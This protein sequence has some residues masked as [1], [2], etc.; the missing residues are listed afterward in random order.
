[1]HSQTIKAIEYLLFIDDTLTT[2]EMVKG[3]QK[4]GFNVSHSSIY[5]YLKK[6]NMNIEKLVK[7]K[8]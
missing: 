8:F 1:M 7:A 2:K 6:L 5:R 3:I 4:D